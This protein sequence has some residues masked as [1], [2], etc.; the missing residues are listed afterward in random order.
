MTVGRED[1]AV[2]P[3]SVIFVEAGMEHRFHTIKEDLS[4]LVFFAPPEY[5]RGLS[6]DA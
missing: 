2:E 1:R 6:S 4:V 5:S 3:G